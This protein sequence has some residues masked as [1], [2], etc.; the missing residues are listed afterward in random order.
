MALYG[1]DRIA[2]FHIVKYLYTLCEQLS[3]I[4]HPVMTSSLNDIASVKAV[5]V[6][7]RLKIF[8]SALSKFLPNSSRFIGTISK[9]CFIL[10]AHD[11]DF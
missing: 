8:D 3:E 1:L 2:S 9:A 11:F 7:G 5:V 4:L 10:L 6:A